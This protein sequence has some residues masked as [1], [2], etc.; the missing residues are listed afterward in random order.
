M[1]AAMFTFAPIAVFMSFHYPE[2][3]GTSTTYF[4]FAGATEI[5]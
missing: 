2:A 5:G 4:H 3:R 1:N